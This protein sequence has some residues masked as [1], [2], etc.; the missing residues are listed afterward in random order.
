[1]NFDNT[2]IFVAKLLFHYMGKFSIE[3][4]ILWIGKVITNE[5]FIDAYRVFEFEQ[6]VA[7]FSRNQ[8]EK[9]KY[10]INRMIYLRKTI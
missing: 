4:P 7:L 3:L 6:S 5:L 1:M 10:L 9:R 8:K 2:E